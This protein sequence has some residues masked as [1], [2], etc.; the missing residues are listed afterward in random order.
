[1]Q[2]NKIIVQLINF[3]FLSLLEGISILFLF[4][5]M[6]IHV[7]FLSLLL[8]SCGNNSNDEFSLQIGDIL[9]QDLDSSPFAMQ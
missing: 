3:T 6:K 4:Y 2:N 1:M 9:F 5:Y 7:F 8:I